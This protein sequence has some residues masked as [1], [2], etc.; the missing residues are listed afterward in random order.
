MSLFLDLRV[1]RTRLIC[2][3]DDRIIQFDDGITFKNDYQYPMN[4]HTLAITS[5]SMVSIEIV[6]LRVLPRLQLL[7]Q[8]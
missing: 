3:N 8:L 7:L 4:K 5:S 2:E 1:Y 6:S